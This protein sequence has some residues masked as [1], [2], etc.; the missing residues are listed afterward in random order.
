[1][2]AAAHTTGYAHPARNCGCVLESRGHRCPAVWRMGTAR[3]G[4]TGQRGDHRLWRGVGRGKGV[5]P[6]PQPG[7]SPSASASEPYRELIEVGLALGRNAMAIWQD[8][9]D[10]HGFTAGYQSVKR[11]VQKLRAVELCPFNSNGASTF[12]CRDWTYSNGAGSHGTKAKEGYKE[13][14]IGL[15]KRGLFTTL[16]MLR[17]QY[18]DARPLS[19]GVTPHNSHFVD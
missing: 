10:G 18:S 19:T 4:K 1:M 11:L 17:L 6:D 12:T 13:V 5:P 15:R 2:V 3:A 9:V 14:V 8:L 16:A 7:R